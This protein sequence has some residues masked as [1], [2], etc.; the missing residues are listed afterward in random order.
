MCAG[1]ELC[2][3]EIVVRGA[4]KLYFDTGAKGVL[5]NVFDCVP[6]NVN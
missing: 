5:P 2:K 6:L 1:E 3:L 4:M